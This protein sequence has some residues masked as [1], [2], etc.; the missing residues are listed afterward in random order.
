MLSIFT[1]DNLPEWV[2][3]E[4]FTEIEARE[5]ITDMSN[6][7]KNSVTIVPHNELTKLFEFDKIKQVN[8]AP[9][10]YV[11]IL[12]GIYSD[13]LAQIVAVR[14]KGLRLLLKVVP[15]VK[16]K[17]GQYNQ[18]L[19][20]PID[21]PDAVSTKTDKMLKHLGDI[22]YS[23]GQKTYLR[24]FLIANFK[25][26]NVCGDNILPT[27]TEAM[28]FENTT[29]TDIKNS[30]RKERISLFQP[31]RSVRG[32]STTNEIIEGVISHK[33]RNTAFIQAKDNNLICDLELPYERIGFKFAEGQKVGMIDGKH[34]GKAGLIVKDKGSQLVVY[35]AYQKRE[36]L[37]KLIDC[38]SYE[39]F[40]NLYSTTNNFNYFDLVSFKG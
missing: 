25:S 12:K 36:I 7:K 6:L 20:S 10:Q 4:A 5:A 11:R 3:I 18:K 37:V 9:G 15:R 38:V 35:D 39:E 19:F 21:H 34:K 1:F 22:K 40:E 26:D 28:I 8:L 27:A 31:G 32:L 17:D 29:P 24:G 2:Y 13:D 30:P 16:G 33:A 14:K 23:F